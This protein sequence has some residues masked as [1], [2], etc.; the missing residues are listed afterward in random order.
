MRM[1]G[2]MYKRPNQEFSRRGSNIF[3]PYKLGENQIKKRF[4]YAL[5]VL[6]A[7]EYYEG[8]DYGKIYCERRE[9]GKSKIY[10]DQPELEKKIYDDFINLNKDATKYL[11]GYTGVGKTTLLRNAFQVFDR[12]IKEKDGNLIIYL[13]FYTT[14]TA[15]EG[16]ERD[17]VKTALISEIEAAITYLSGG[18]YVERL[19]QYNDDF[20]KE[21][22]EYIYKNNNALIHQ[23]P[24]NPIY[25]AE[26]TEK[27]IYRKILDD[28]ANKD[29]LDYS[30]SQLKFFLKKYKKRKGTNFKNIVFIFDDIE[31]RSIEY[32]SELMELAWHI[33]KCLQTFKDR[34][35]YLKILISL[36]NYS[37]RMHCIR[38]KEAFREIEKD[39]IILKDYVPSLSDVLEKRVDYVLKNKKIV[40]KVKEPDSWKISVMN[41]EIILQKLYG[42]YDKMILDLTHNNLFKSMQLL[43]RILTNK[44]HL[45]KYE[46]FNEGAFVI[47]P[48]N[49]KLTNKS[50]DKAV[51]GNDDVFYSLVYGEEDAYQDTNDYYMTNI[52]HYIKKE[53]K[54]TELMGI[55]IIQ[56]LIKQK[57]CIA[58]DVYD[59][60]DSKE[61]NEIVDEILD[62]F[63]LSVDEQK[64]MRNGLKA[65]MK[66][67]YEGGVLLQSF[68][69][70]VLEDDEAFK[71][72]YR[73]DMKVYLSF[74]GYRLYCLLEANSLL[75]QT[76]RDDIDTNIEENDI[77]TLQLSKYKRIKYCLQY[78]E[79][80][81]CKETAYIVRAK[82]KKLFMECFGEKVSVVILMLGLRESINIYFSRDSNER[83]E[84]RKAYNAL[85]RKI[86]IFLEQ[87]NNRE[88]LDFKTLKLFME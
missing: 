84:S 31:T 67:L 42:E 18:T 85:A 24:N 83:D 34:D 16:D 51:L 15:I 6:L 41:L 71:R 72:E 49:Y 43:M 81:F 32:Q 36:R 29:P 68:I 30:L 20:Y 52:M 59:G 27:N 21:F 14:I 39:D 80:L 61:G 48:K 74:R 69:E 17:I 13:S 79:Y 86:N 40:E 87:I 28:L 50:V 76:Y 1:N 66:K 7:S 25:T 10:V 56:F 4:R 9:D 63:S 46:I 60:F 54:E 62:I 53:N 11:V 82:S 73:E 37:F 5:E 12:N 35:F 57:L 22:Y 44:R 58:T 45:G 23:Y 3:N 75:F 33:K 78:C 65:M 38:A 88:S 77:L 64:D 8:T 19:M 70:P 26:L 2:E 47:D 55:Y